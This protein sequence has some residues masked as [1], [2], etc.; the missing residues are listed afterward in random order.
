MKEIKLPQGVWYYDQKQ[1]LG[2]PGGF[3]AVFLGQD[4]KGK[5]VA[6]KKLHSNAKDFAHRELSAAAL[7]Q[8][9]SPDNVM[10]ILDCGQA[11]GTDDYFL[12]MPAA[13]QNLQKK[14]DDDTIV[15]ESEAIA[16][17]Q[18]I[19][20]GLST[21]GDVIHRDLK[22]HNIL[23]HE[24]VWKIADYGIAKFIEESTAPQT[25]KKC[26]SPPYASPEQWLEDSVT[27]AADM[28]SLGCIAY[29]LITGKPPFEA[30][31]REELKELHLEKAPPKCD[32][33]TT[34][35][36]SL[37]STM[38]RKAPDSRPSIG[39]VLDTLNSL[40]EKK[41]NIH[42]SNGLEALRVADAE[43]SRR[44]AE[45]EASLRSAEAKRHTR[46]KLREEGESIL[47]EC[48][49]DFEQW[50]NN[51]DLHV[52]V[53]RSAARISFGLGSAQLE[54]DVSTIQSVPR[55]DPLPASQWDIVCRASMKIIQQNPKSAE[56]SCSLYF[57]KTPE[58][59][60][61]RWW[62]LKFDFNPH[63]LMRPHR[64]GREDGYF[65][66]DDY[67]SIDEA[68]APVMSR[69]QLTEPPLPIDGE[70]KDEARN[71]WAVLLARASQG[72]L[73]L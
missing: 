34:K 56:R 65:A 66:L 8:E 32:T 72:R 4:D 35:L 13:D 37:I 5:K 6:V 54:F 52:N 30:H 73:E 68:L 40:N 63:P 70:D 26:L 20:F 33:C 12:V 11:A 47:N 22:P 57:A 10:P 53:H 21:F 44:A 9:L 16:I 46:E 36:Q 15:S 50:I 14:I 31:S 29:A 43:E 25:L 55:D 18:Q 17:L 48:I 67:E 28:Y 3:G 45:E 41:S 59:Q 69:Y 49:D 71:R 23:L 24:N 38:L 51:D 42:V 61:Y 27:P 2:K 62:E 39:R 58:T 1:P 64:R 60:D 7:I 19:A